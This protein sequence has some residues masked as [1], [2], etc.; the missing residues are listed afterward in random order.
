MSEMTPT[1]DNDTLSRRQILASTGAAGLALV[2]GCTGDETDDDAEEEDVAGLSAAWIYF[3][4]VGDLGW[5]FSHNEGYEAT[6]ERLPEVETSVVESVAP[7]DVEQTAAQFAEDGYDVIFGASAD[8]TDGMAAA[9][10]QY[11]DTAFEVASG[12]DTGPNY[13]AY[14]TKLYQARYL[15]GYAA[16]LVTETN[17]IGYVAA[18][19]VSTVYQDINGFASGLEDANEDA[20]LYV[21]WT[22]DWFDPATEGENAQTVID[23]HDVDV[24]AQHQDSPAALETAADNEIWATGYAASMRDQI[25][26]DYYLMT[27][28]FEWEE[29]YTQIIEE[30]GEGAWEAGV[31]FPGLGSGAAV[32]DPGP[33]VPDDVVEEVMEIRDEMLEGDGDEIVWGGTPFEDWSDEEILFDSDD[34][35]IDNIEGDVI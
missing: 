25:D 7:A 23:D 24:M 8:Y 2:A 29:V 6:A 26:E 15:V 11:P 13:G 34:F 9:S 32:S 22:N 31:T 4:E 10:E 33:A 16:G 28:I 3:A 30:V 27:P 20:T 21:Q 17:N 12:I 19:P 18:N 1:F 14:Y 35:L 5:T